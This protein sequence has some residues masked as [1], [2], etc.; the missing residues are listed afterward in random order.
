V[1][2]FTRKKG[3]KAMKDRAFIFYGNPCTICMADPEVQSFEDA[4]SRGS[5]ACPF[6]RQGRGCSSSSWGCVQLAGVK[7]AR[8]VLQF[9]SEASEETLAMEREQFRR[10]APLPPHQ[11]EAYIDTPEHNYGRITDPDLVVERIC[12]YARN[13]LDIKPGERVFRATVEEEWTPPLTVEAEPSAAGDER[14]EP[15]PAR[16]AA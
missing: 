3:G 1:K 9:Y 7:M 10:R 13:V 14:M 16:R 4:K 15:P 11:V 6:Y 8:Y 5:S 2:I 12:E